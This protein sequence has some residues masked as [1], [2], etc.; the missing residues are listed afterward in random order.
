[1]DMKLNARI[2]YLFVAIIMISF[3]VQW[4]GPYH[5]AH[6]QLGVSAQAAILM[7]AES[8]RILYEKNSEQSL[9]IASITKIMTAIVA[10]ENG[11]LSDK[12]KTSKN[13]FGVEGS[14]I[15][16]KLGEKLSLEN[17]IYGLMLRSGNDA[18]VA[19]AEHIGGSLE[20]FVFLM[21]KKAEELGMTE[22][23]F[24]NPHGLD[25]HE[26]HYSSARD[27][28]VLTAYAMKNEDF[29]TIVG[30][31]RK[32]APLQGSKWDRV[33]HNKNRML[34]KYPYAEGVKTGYTKRAKR[35]LVSSATKEGHRLIAVTLNAPDDWNDHINMFEYG[36]NHYTK[37]TIAEKNEKL[38][39]ERLAREDGY[40]R[41]MNPFHY[42]LT[43]EE[44]VQKKVALDPA[45]RN[46]KLTEIPYP[47]GYL[48]FYLNNEEIGRVA[49]EFVKD[50]PVNDQPEEKSFWKTFLGFIK[51]IVG[52]V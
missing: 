6:A 2:K 50:Q 1:M 38:R 34:T 42:P 28:A 32:T 5:K 49:I 10:L 22:T 9:R 47:A 40:F 13:A 24:S 29:A 27:M 8:G 33:W 20:G 37:A 19:I 45:F 35:T 36:F 39:D 4:F 30:T 17:M 14:S 23:V 44:R 43:K 51:R 11:K 3:L 46:E 21:N 48:K 7:D 31:K 15:Y 41:I 18:A 25:D 16:L 52:G 26:E 12:V